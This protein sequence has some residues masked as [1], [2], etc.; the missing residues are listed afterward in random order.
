VLAVLRLKPNTTYYYRVVSTDTTGKKVTFPALTDP[1]KSF[2]TPALDKVAPKATTPKVTALPDGTA[3]VRWTTDEPAT[4]VVRL[5]TAS[6]KLLQRSRAKALTVEH[7]MLLTDLDPGK[8]YW[9]DAVSIDKAG[10]RVVTAPAKFI[11]PATGVAQHSAAAFLLGTSSGDTTVD[12]TGLGAITLGGKRA[13]ARS[14]SYVSGVLDARAMVDWDRAVWAADL[15]S[16]STAVLRVR[17]GST[18]KPDD[19]WSDWQTVPLKTG[20]LGGSSR[21]IQYQLELTSAAGATAPSLYAIGFSSNAV[22]AAD[23][24]EGGR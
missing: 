21:L 18:D 3:L 5:G 22:L 17:T 16:G 15:P 8:T 24:H 20:R 4:T 9:Y 23:D 12:E 19:T 7:Q 14:G 10:N 11:T 2:T 6:G 13:V 1:P